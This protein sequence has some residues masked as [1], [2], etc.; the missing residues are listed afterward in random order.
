MQRR[1]AT[2]RHSTAADRAT[3]RRHDE[4]AKLLFIGEVVADG[5][6]AAA[7]EVAATLRLDT[8]KPL[9]TEYVSQERTKRFGDAV[10]SVKLRKG[11]FR[12]AAPGR[13]A[14]RKYLLVPTEFQHR[15]DAG[16]ARRVREYTAEMEGHYRHQGLIRTGEHPLVLARPYGRVGS[17]LRELLAYGFACA[18]HSG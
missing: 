10:F 1:P 7:P 4:A 12:A 11:R 6:R 14:R 13:R 17:S 9:P 8:I 5:I 18:H 2:T 16:M 3:R 15:D